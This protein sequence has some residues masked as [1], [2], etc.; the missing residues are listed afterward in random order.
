[1]LDQKSFPSRLADG[2]SPALQIMTE[3]LRLVNTQGLQNTWNLRN[4]HL[5]LT[6]LEGIAE[7]HGGLHLCPTVSLF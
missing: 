7:D 3:E 6:T 5:S 2:F 1:M 4:C